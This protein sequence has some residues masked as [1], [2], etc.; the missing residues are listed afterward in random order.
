MTGRPSSH[1]LT[2]PTSMQSWLA[3][4]AVRCAPSTRPNAKG[5]PSLSAP[6]RPTHPIPRSSGMATRRQTPAVPGVT[7]PIPCSRSKATRFR[8][9]GARPEVKHS[10]PRRP[11]KQ[12]TDRPAVS[13]PAPAAAGRLPLTR[14]GGRASRSSTSPRLM[15]SQGARQRPGRRLQEAAA[16]SSGQK[17][18]SACK[19]SHVT[20]AGIS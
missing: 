8:H 4:P 1:R 17:R 2:G 13:G 10:A 20:M 16:T 5:S 3:G 18:R 12:V 14:M 19:L 15:Q 11:H 6:L 7:R 9:H